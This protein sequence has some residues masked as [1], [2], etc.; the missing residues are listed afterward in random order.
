[1]Y[2]WAVFQA[3]PKASVTVSV[4]WAL[5]GHYPNVPGLEP[6][7]P[8]EGPVILTICRPVPTVVNC[9]PGLNAAKAPIDAG[10]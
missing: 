3:M 4:W 10:L 2:L 7:S 5:A 9:F 8:P 1:M 6:E